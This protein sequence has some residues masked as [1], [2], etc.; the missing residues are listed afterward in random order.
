M[1]D[2]DDFD[3]FEVP[4]MKRVLI[5]VW[6]YICFVKLGLGAF[7][8]SSDQWIFMIFGCAICFIL[9]CFWMIVVCL[10]GLK[11]W[12]VDPRGGFKAQVDNQDSTSWGLHFGGSARAKIMKCHGFKNALFSLLILTSW[13]FWGAI[14]MVLHCIFIKKTLDV[15]KKSPP[16]YGAKNPRTVLF[17]LRPR[18][19]L[20][21]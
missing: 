20:H 11:G 16:P 18:K 9:L 12:N 14:W 13:C 15:C 3:V 1:C 8:G 7:E 10:G 17:E 6:F 5:L 2:V 21:H 4:R 19:P